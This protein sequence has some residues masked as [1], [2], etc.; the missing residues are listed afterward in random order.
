MGRDMLTAD[1][2][3]TYSL[4]LSHG[5]AW[6]IGPCKGADAGVCSWVE[7][8]AS[9]L[10]LEPAS[11]GFARRIRVDRVRNDNG[12]TENGY[13]QFTPSLPAGLPREGWQAWGRSGM[14]L[15][16]HP[17]VPDV[18]CGLFHSRKPAVERMRRA[19]IPIFEETIRSGGLPIHGALVETQGV[20]V[21]LAGRSGVG[22]TTCCKR[23]PSRWQVLSD[24]MSLVS[25]SAWGGYRAH[26]MPTWSTF[27]SDK[28]HWPCRASRSVPLRAL[29]ILQQAS[30]DG[31]VPLAG[32]K[33]ALMV[34]T[35]C[36][37][38]ALPIY[39]VGG[40]DDS[41]LRTRIFENAVSLAGAVPVFR[42]RVSLEGR[43]WER[44]EDVLGKTG[45]PVSGVRLSGLEGRNPAAVPSDVSPRNGWPA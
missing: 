15:L 13:A 27:E 3:G 35:A 20:G 19:L 7:A 45:L 31:V 8:F 30:E 38:V 40:P 25:P 11:G 14:V 42:L 34:E 28:S 5:A 1:P 41:S 39:L 21:L 23:L 37:E 10:G 12:Q 32:A 29:F 33:A 6:D 18:F 17:K 24:D 36:G 26:P 2:D 4:I 44:I 22:K 9:Y 43:F 16:R